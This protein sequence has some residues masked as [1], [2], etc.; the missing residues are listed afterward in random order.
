MN[1][2]RNERYLIMLA[3]RVFLEFFQFLRLFEGLFRLLMVAL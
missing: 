3:E 1:K 2:V